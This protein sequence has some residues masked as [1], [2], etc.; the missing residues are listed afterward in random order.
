MGDQTRN[1]ILVYVYE[2][3]RAEKLS[4]DQLVLEDFKESKIN[5]HLFLL[6]YV[7]GLCMVCVNFSRQFLYKKK[8]QSFRRPKLNDSAIFLVTLETWTERTLENQSLKKEWIEFPTFL[9]TQYIELPAFMSDCQTKNT[10]LKRKE[11]LLTKRHGKSAEILS[12][13]P[14]CHC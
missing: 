11:K 2:F 4:S 9:A 13:W 14:E 10:K 7:F 8:S 5:I 1:Q 3:W 6:W 12:W